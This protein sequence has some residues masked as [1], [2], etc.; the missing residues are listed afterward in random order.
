MIVQVARACGHGRCQWTTWLRLCGQGCLEL[1]EEP[2]A[3][4]SM[5]AWRKTGNST[6]WG[7]NAA[8]VDLPCFEGSITV[9]IRPSM[10]PRTA[11]SDEHVDYHKR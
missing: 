8:R 10:F 9:I 11:C 7:N 3:Y 2:R 4:R 5:E 1:K 6:R